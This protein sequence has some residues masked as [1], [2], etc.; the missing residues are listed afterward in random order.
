MKLM[1]NYIKR[2]KRYLV[3][4]V[5]CAFGFALIEL[6]LPTLLAMMIDKGVAVKDFE[7]VKKIGLWMI[8]ICSVGLIG[9]LSLAYSVSRMT[10]FIMRDLRRDIFRKIQGYS[11]LEYGK[12]GAASLNTRTMNDVYKIMTF[13]QTILR[14]GIIAPLMFISSFIMIIKTSPFLSWGLFIAIPIIIVGV[15]FIG[16]NA[17]PLSTNQQLGLDGINM[18]FKENLTGLRVIRAF[19]N[20]SFQ[21]E[22]FKEVNNNYTKTSRK[23]FKLM[24]IA[25]PGFSFIFNII[26]AFIIWFGAKL[27]GSGDLLVG[28]LVA[29]IEYIFHAMFSAMLFANVFMMYPLAAVSANRIQ[30][31]LDSNSEIHHRE[32]GIAKTETKGVIEFQDVTFA[33]PGESEE[34]VIKNVSFTAKPGETV[35]FIGSTGSGKSTLIQ[36]IPRF[37]DVTRGRILIDGV[38]VKDYDIKILRQKI[39]YVPQKALLFTGTIEDNLRYGKH[40][41]TLEELKDAVRVAQAEDFINQKPDG[42]ETFLSEGGSNLSGGQ[43]QRLAI[44]RAIVRKPEIYIFDDSFSA[45]DYRTDLKLRTALKE[46]TKDSTVLIVAQRVGTIKNADKIIVLNEGEVVA[47]GTHKELL[48]TSNIYYDIASSQLSKEELMKDEE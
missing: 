30:E 4:S 11:H 37:Y 13:L 2:Y 20:E 9:L 36:L 18:I 29:F 17:Q 22:R 12:F 32:N 39:G 40:N 28:N 10:T 14:I 48:K 41:L 7:V 45:L 1:W 16:K 42:F 19:G 21:E 23:L 46:K 34:P 5:F 27:V 38:D 33:Y 3:L 6:G 24:G 47:Q 43:K 44:A 31:I 35:A 15:I 26:F 25:Q 8:G